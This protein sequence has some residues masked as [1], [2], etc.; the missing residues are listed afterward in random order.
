MI[1][2]ESSGEN[3]PVTF[4]ASLP[5]SGAALTLTTVS[6][7]RYCDTELRHHILKRY[8]SDQVGKYAA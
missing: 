5:E 4:L 8:Q 2:M 3:R 1:G 6:Q 7:S